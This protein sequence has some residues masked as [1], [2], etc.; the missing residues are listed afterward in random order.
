MSKSELKHIVSRSKKENFDNS[1]TYEY[2]TEKVHFKSV[3]VRQP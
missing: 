3:R 1:V 2:E